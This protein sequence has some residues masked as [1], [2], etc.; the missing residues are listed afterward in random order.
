VRFFSRAASDIMPA[1]P[2]QPVS[3]VDLTPSAIPPTST[4]YA[5]FGAE[6]GDYDSPT[7][8]TEEIRQKVNFSVWELGTIPEGMHFIGATGEPNRVV[9]L[10]DIGDERVGVTLVEEPYNPNSELAK[11]EIGAS[12]LVEPVQIGLYTGEYVHGSWS[13]GMADPNRTWDPAAGNQ[14]LHWVQ[15]NVFI[16]MQNWGPA[17]I[18]NKAS[19][20]EWAASLTTQLVSASFTP[21]P[22]TA[23]PHYAV[24]YLGQDYGLSLAEATVK[25]G[26]P[27]LEP[28]RLPGGLSFGGAAYEADKK[29]ARSLYIF[30]RSLL[31]QGIPF[32]LQISQQPATDTTNCNLCSF[33]RGAYNGI[34]TSPK[35]MTVGANAIIVPVQVGQHPGEYVEGEWIKT[36][37][38]WQW[39]DD[40][41]I[42]LSRQVLRWQ[43]DGMAF[44]ISYLAPLALTQADLI[45]IAESLK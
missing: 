28:T 5:A 30:D 23:S 45:A 20:L 18:V 4:P 33:V 35:G 24:T 22:P 42:M 3:W 15:D 41:T 34:E 13:N 27:L 25:A 11:W 7:C 17:A 40:P 6:C 12:A 29:I 26:Y 37:Q 21:L 19:F 1:Y 31:D 10:Y 9:L 39:A 44:E 8:T 36:D 32:A 2:T 43:A 14:T 38:G 16:S